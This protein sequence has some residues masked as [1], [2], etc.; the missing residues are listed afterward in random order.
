MSNTSFL[1]HQSYF[2]AIINSIPSIS[3]FKANGDQP[4]PIQ[5]SIDARNYPTTPVKARI[6]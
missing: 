4:L 3:S 1:L 5:N 6:K 2:H